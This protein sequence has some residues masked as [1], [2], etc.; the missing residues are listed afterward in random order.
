MIFNTVPPLAD[1][2]PQGA[3]AHNA[4]YRGKYLGSEVTD[5]QWAAISAGTFD[6]LYIGDYWTIGG[7]NYRI[8]AFDYY[9]NTGDTLC[10]QH[11]VVMVP[12]TA[13]YEASMDDDTSATGAY[14]GTKMYKSGLA[15]AKSTVNNAF[16]AAHILKHRQFLTNALTADY[17]SAGSWYDS[18][19]ELMAERN[20][21]GCAVYTNCV[22]GTGWPNNYTI[23]A[24]QYPLFQFAPDKRRADPGFW[25]R[26]VASKGYYSV[27]EFSGAATYRIATEVVGVRPAF[28]IC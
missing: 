19:L 28:S 21:Y 18:T 23:D 24:T 3:G 25:L 11:H 20:L 8:A 26:D 4:I 9:L 5:D 15:S 10:T 27:V 16:G 6:D 14:V 7:V 1:I 2:I 12:D 17:A 22:N 13:L